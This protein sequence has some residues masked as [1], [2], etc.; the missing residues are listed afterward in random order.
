LEGAADELRRLG[1]RVEVC[2]ADVR[3]YD[4]LSAA[5]DQAVSSLGPVNVLVCGAAGNFLCSAEE[6]SPARFKAVVDIDLVGTFQATLACFQS[7]KRTR[8][9]ALFISSGQS[10]IP[11][12]LQAH[13]GAAK[14]GVDNLMRNLAL[15]WGPHGIRV[16]SIL[17]GPIRDTEGMRRLAPGRAAEALAREIPLGRFGTTED[18]GAAAVFLASPLARYITGATLSVD[19]GQNLPG[20]GLFSR[21]V[22]QART[23]SGSDAE[24]KG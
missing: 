6:L 18:I 1:A 10:V 22:S 8:G 9:S 2:V 19:G 23:L 12:A 7:L 16:N 3:D 13:A 5:V 4:R 21:C 14:A 17:P 11:Y 24:S 15:E 20:S